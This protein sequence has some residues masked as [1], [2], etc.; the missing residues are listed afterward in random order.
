VGAEVVGG[1]AAAAAQRGW[2]GPP[3]GGVECVAMAVHP[4]RHRARIGEFVT[5]AARAW[6]RR[7][8]MH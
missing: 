8:A 1:G 5:K 7:P 6:R 3:P 2:I 4:G